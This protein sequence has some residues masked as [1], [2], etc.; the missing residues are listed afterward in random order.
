M[1]DE[2]KRCPYCGE[3][4]L[5]IAKKCKH[6]GEFLSDSSAPPQGTTLQADQSE[7]TLWEGNP[8]H[9][10]FLGAYII[11]GILV[12]AYG[13]GLIIIIWALLNKTSRVFTITNK[14]I[15]SKGGIIARSTREVTLKDIR[16][17]NLKQNIIER[18]FNLGTIEIGSAGT[19][20]IEVTFRG[21]P[22]AP[23]IKNMVAELKDRIS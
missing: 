17:I 11:G 15:K 22:K 18:L 19:A 8:S 13:L 12:L 4:I 6:C 23:K 5:L 14:R 16:S 3:K 7:E 10:Y 9:Y 20:G 2:T 21:I 1:A